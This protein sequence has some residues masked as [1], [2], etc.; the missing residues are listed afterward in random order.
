M[1]THAGD[2][3]LRLADLDRWRQCELITAEQAAAIW[4]D[5][6]P[7]RRRPQLATIAAYFGAFMILLAYTIFVG[8]EWE[9]LGAAGRAAICGGTIAALWVGGWL[10]R[11]VART[12]GDLLIFAGSGIVPLLVHTLLVLAGLWPEGPAYR[13]FYRAVLPAWVGMEVVSIAVA[14]AV[15]RLTRFPLT[16]LLVAFWCWYLSM[17]LVRWLSGAEYWSWDEREQLASAAMGL[18]MLVAGWQ[19]QR[20]A[21]RDYSLWLY[22]FGHIAVLTNLGALAVSREGWYALAYPAL[23]VG[24][25][26][27]SVRLGRRIFLVFGAL[28]VYSYLCYLAFDVFEGALGFTFGLAAVGLLVLLGGAAYQ[29]WLRHTA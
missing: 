9:R 28:G 21:E 13:D 10:L 14:L 27:A 17:D 24:F 23:Y 8:L 7:L 4:Q 19:L 12:A 2:R 16:V 29:R 11:R 18:A 22:L 6:A 1:T 15:V 3:L 26:A 20:R 5:A 25:V